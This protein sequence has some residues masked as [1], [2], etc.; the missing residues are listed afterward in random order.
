MDYTLYFKEN[1]GKFPFR[2]SVWDPKI[3]DGG[4]ENT[5]QV[6]Y[7]YFYIWPY[8]DVYTVCDNNGFI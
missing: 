1:G 7:I 6:S 3:S 5:W 2:E 8:E 4:L